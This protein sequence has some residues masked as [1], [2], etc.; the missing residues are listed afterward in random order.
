MAGGGERD[1]RTPVTLALG[2]EPALRGP[3]GG[4]AAAY[5]RLEGAPVAGDAA[6]EEARRRALH[7]ERGA[8]RRPVDDL[9]AVAADGPHDRLGDPLGR[10]LHA[11]LPGGA[12]LPGRVLG[13]E[14]GGH[15]ARQHDGDA[16][17]AA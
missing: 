5:E 3:R 9:E 1:H 13:E 4:R 2:P 16:D 14:S 6:A 12:T 17:A 15:L 8:H 11:A 7:E 10:Y